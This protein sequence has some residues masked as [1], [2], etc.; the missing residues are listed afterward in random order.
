MKQLTAIAFVCV[1]LAVPAISQQVTQQESNSKCTAEV[2]NMFP[3]T[4]NN[5]RNRDALEKAKTYPDFGRANLQLGP[6]GNITKEKLAGIDRISVDIFDNQVVTYSVYYEDQPHGVRWDNIDQWVVKLS[7]TLKLPDV[8][9]W[10]TSPDYNSRKTLDCEGV[11]IIADVQSKGSIRIINDD[12]VPKQVT[13]RE[14]AY[15]EQKR[16]EFKP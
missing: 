1:L 9:Q 6:A 13:A 11:K 12:W 5:E 4:V 14:K 2:L 3:D 10:T 8:S 15:A 7:E 16:R